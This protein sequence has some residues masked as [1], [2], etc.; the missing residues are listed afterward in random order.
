MIY[1]N[2]EE[3]EQYTEGL[4]AVLTNGNWRQYMTGKMC[5]NI[6]FDKPK[7]PELCG[8]ILG[9]PYYEEISIEKIVSCNTSVA[10]REIPSNI[11]RVINAVPYIVDNKCMPIAVIKFEEGYYIENG[12]HRFYAH[13]LLQKKTIPVSIRNIDDI[14]SKT[15]MISISKPYYNNDGMPLAY[16]E[17]VLD[18]YERYSVIFQCVKRVEM[19]QKNGISILT[20][21]L[22]N[23]DAIIFN[24]CCSSGNR[25]RS[26]QITCELLQKIGYLVDM[27]YI[28]S[29]L[30]FCLE[31]KND[32]NNINFNITTELFKIEKYII[33]NLVQKKTWDKSEAIQ[34]DLF[35]LHD[36][37]CRNGIEYFDTSASSLIEVN[38]T[39]YY[40]VGTEDNDNGGTLYFFEDTVFP[41]DNLKIKFIGAIRKGECYYDLFN[42][43]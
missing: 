41:F 8:A 5:P 3:Y 24:G 15:N 38:G 18:F 30:E 11:E 13:L 1:E 2:R 32:A 34:K 4:Q 40:I 29:H 25:Q 22:E 35:K 42:L 28:S 17:K 19:A 12:K 20:L 23:A 36:F 10:R 6:Y 27:D 16:P 7:V 21:S 43:F 39:Y 26:S 31:N 14:S 37:I 9:N 33:P